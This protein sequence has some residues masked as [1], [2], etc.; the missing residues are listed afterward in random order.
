MIVQLAENIERTK[1]NKLDMKQCINEE[2]KVIDF[3]S[4]KFGRNANLQ[5]HAA[6][7]FDSL[8]GEFIVSN[9]KR[10]DIIATI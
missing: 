4:T 9:K 8:N 7:M 10:L 5:Q 1:K 3:A 6:K 2:Q